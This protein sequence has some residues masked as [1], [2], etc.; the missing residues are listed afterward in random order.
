[1][2]IKQLSVFIENREGRLAQ[3]TK[4]LAQNN[5][6]IRALSIAETTDYGILRLIVNDPDRAVEALRGAGI[7][8]SLTNVIGVAI[9]DRPGGFDAV[10]Q[11][12]AARSIDV[13]YLYAF[14]GRSENK[15]FVILRV[16]DN[17]AAINVLREGGIRVILQEDIF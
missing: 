10:I 1:M 11:T 2:T 17:G 5:I 8:V 6:D 14:V 16:E 12:L 4:I 7:T 9:D 15:A 13:Q 3:I